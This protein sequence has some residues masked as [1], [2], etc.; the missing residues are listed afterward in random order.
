MTFIIL[1]WGAMENVLE[2]RNNSEGRKVYLMKMINSLMI[3]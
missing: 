3:H 1:L 2:E